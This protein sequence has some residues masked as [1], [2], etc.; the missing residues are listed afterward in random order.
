M[1]KYIY[2]FFAIILLILLVLGIFAWMLFYG[3]MDYHI[4]ISK[5]TTYVTE[6]L[7]P[8]GRVDYV[9]AIN[10]I[11]GRGVTPE[12]NMAIPLIQLLGIDRAYS[13]N[14]AF[15]KLMEVTS[16]E[17]RLRPDT[18]RFYRFADFEQ[19]LDDVPKD[20][21]YDIY[22]PNDRGGSEEFRAN[23][24]ALELH[25]KLA[26]HGPWS[27]EEFP[28]CNEWIERNGPVL[29]LAVEAS[30]R[31][32]YF[33]PRVDIEDS[34]V[35]SASYEFSEKIFEVAKCLAARA[36]LRYGRGEIDGAWRDTLAL[37]RLTRCNSGIKEIVFSS[38]VALLS[39]PM[40]CAEKQ[41]KMAAQFFVIE[42]PETE[43]EFLSLIWRHNGLEWIQSIPRLGPQERWSFLDAEPQLETSPTERAI[44]NALRRRVNWDT[45]LKRY[46]DHYDQFIAILNSPSCPGR[47][48]ELKALRERDFGIA[49]S[50]SPGIPS[51]WE[52]IEL[53]DILFAARPT[54]LV[55][56]HISQYESGIF[57]YFVFKNSDQ[58]CARWRL[59]ELAARLALYRSERGEY[60]DTLDPLLTE[61]FGLEPAAT[62]LLDD[63]FSETGRFQ[64]AKTDDGYLL[65]SIDMDGK[66]NGGKPGFMIEQQNPP[67]TIM[68]EE[69]DIG[70]QIGAAGIVPPRKDLP[71]EMWKLEKVF[72]DDEL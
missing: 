71:K 70:F 19:T 22:D 5:E 36:M 29:D 7:L 66:A 27:A 46:N 17:L 3:D 26:M 34:T 37:A 59:I 8:D 54:E 11:K 60:P 30:R 35:F 24:N 67:S 25:Q 43:E 55:W 33:I 58:E 18:P 39:D 56:K 52:E 64:Y 53:T 20:Q 9:G 14:P 15:C 65:Y 68:F 13:E 50:S 16:A 28:Y 40:I 61:S 38:V 44:R 49:P 41:R 32:D 69:G 72:E 23:R 6:P 47:L 62:E 1:K 42:P 12:T 4:T 21:R 51:A 2:W 63:P 48:D 10:E 57:Y 31:P 45:I